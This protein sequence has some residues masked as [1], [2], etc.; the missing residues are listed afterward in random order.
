MHHQSHANIKP[1]LK[2]RVRPGAPG[3]IVRSVL[4]QGTGLTWIDL[5]APLP[6]SGTI[7]LETGAPLHRSQFGKEIHLADEVAGR[8]VHVKK[9]SS[10]SCAIVTF[11][12]CAIRDS[13][14]QR[15]YDMG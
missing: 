3:N 12:N 15:C 10:M 7:Q 4:A 6:M 11:S 2:F 14:L 5:P 13:V 8:M 9:H 1:Y